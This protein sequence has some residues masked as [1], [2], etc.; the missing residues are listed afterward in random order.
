MINER[1][2]GVEAVA[3]LVGRCCIL[4]GRVDVNQ[5]GVDVDDQR[6]VPGR[7]LRGVEVA[8]CVPRAGADLSHRPGHRFVDGVGVVG[9]LVDPPVCG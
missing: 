2:Q 4:L 9:E 7:G 8:E 1:A 6:V 3:A 5:G